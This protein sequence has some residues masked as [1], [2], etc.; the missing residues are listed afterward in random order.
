MGV[1]DEAE[2]LEEL[3]CAVDGRDVHC[4]GSTTNCAGDLLRRAVPELPD[5]LE[6][7]LALRRQAVAAG[8]KLRLP[9]VPG[10]PAAPPARNPTL[11]HMPHAVLAL[12]TPDGPVLVDPTTPVLRAEDFGV[13]RGESVFETTRVVGGR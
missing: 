11:R 5:R 4:R 3:E 2:L 10:G 8:T 6:D 1:L 13:V 12:L 7:Q 9:V